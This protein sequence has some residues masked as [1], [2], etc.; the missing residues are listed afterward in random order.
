LYDELLS[1]PVDHPNQVFTR[2]RAPPSP[3]NIHDTFTTG[4]WSG[5]NNYSSSGGSYCI[6]SIWYIPCICVNKLLHFDHV[7]S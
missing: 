1:V 6:C 4:T 5:Y 7:S 2:V 3:G